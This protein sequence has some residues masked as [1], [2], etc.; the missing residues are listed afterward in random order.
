LPQS[1][2]KVAFLEYYLQ[3][4]RSF[5]KRLPKGLKDMELTFSLDQPV[6]V[7]PLIQG[8]RS[9]VLDLNTFLVEMREPKHSGEARI[10]SAVGVTR[11]LFYQ[12]NP[13]LA[14]QDG[15]LELREALDIMGTSDAV[16]NFYLLGDELTHAFSS[17]FE[18]DKMWDRLSVSVVNL[19]EM[20]KKV[21][22]S[23]H[24]GHICTH[25]ETGNHYHF[26]F[27]KGKPLGVY[28]LENKWSPVNI[29]SVFSQA[30]QLD[31][32]RSMEIEALLSKAEEP[33]SPTEF[34]EFMSA[35]NAFVETIAS[36]VGRKPTEKSLQKNFVGANLFPLDGIQMKLGSDTYKSAHVALEFFSEGVKGFLKDMAVIVGKPWLDEKLQVFSKDN[37]KLIEK[38]SLKEKIL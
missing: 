28:D 13:V 24:T 12:G 35:W 11:I 7:Q 38:M 20:L 2:I 15:R 25:T 33:F 31:Y 18:G 30:K 8:L 9:S 26:F 34:R 27:R 14:I 37:E 4:D 5:F 21:V 16:L 23:G 19:D 3:K 29:S 36:K 10:T 17:I 32:Y 22:S 1:N 6:E